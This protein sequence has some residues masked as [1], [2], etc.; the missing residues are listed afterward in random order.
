MTVSGQRPSFWGGNKDYLSEYSTKPHWWACQSTLA[1]QRLQGK[2]MC[3]YS[4]RK[5]RLCKN[6]FYLAWGSL[7]CFCVGVFL[8]QI[9]VT[10]FC[11]GRYW[12]KTGSPLSWWDSE[13]QKEDKRST[14]WTWPKK[15]CWTK[16]SPFLL[17]VAFLAITS[18]KKGRFVELR[19]GGHCW[20]P[21]QSSHVP[22]TSRLSLPVTH[23]CWLSTPVTFLTALSSSNRQ[24]WRGQG[25]SP[26]DL[27]WEKLWSVIYG[28]EFPRASGWSWDFSWI[29][30]LTCLLAL[31]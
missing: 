21:T 4:E 16:F 10:G 26:F 13:I 15:H 25:D 22:W 28:P 8:L 5:N 11:L 29:R 20:G 2:Q 6:H 31:P 19:C 14:I 24:V 1:Y 7:L 30:S 27:S 12:N 17:F 23:I 9:N 18:G 3:Q